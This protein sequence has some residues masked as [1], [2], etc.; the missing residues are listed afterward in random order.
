MPVIESEHFEFNGDTNED[1]GVVFDLND[2]FS[3]CH[4]Y[5]SITASIC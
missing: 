5:V 4:R 3:I 2:L 1:M